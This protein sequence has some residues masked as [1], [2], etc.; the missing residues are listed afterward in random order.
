MQDQINKAFADLNALCH[1]RDQAWAARKMD[2]TEAFLAQAKI[3]HMDGVVSYSSGYGRFDIGMAMNA[4]YGSA[5]MV[6]LL[7][8][9]GRAGGLAAMAKNSDAQI[10]KRDAAIIKALNKA[11]IHELPEF[12]LIECSDGYEGS[13]NVA[14]RVVSI[15]TILAG[16]YNIQRLHQRTLVKVK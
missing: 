5:A 2:S 11:G 8:G 9:R 13:F 12:E 6:N 7:S 3:D 10:A 15:R 14:G 1:E 4:H 16:G